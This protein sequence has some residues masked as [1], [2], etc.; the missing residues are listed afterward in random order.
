M[1]RR[2]QRTL[3]RE[4]CY[5]GVGIHFGKSASLTLQPAQANTGII[6][7]RFD[8]SGKQQDVPALLS[9]VYDTGRST[10]LSEGPVIVATVEHLL[11]ALR[12]SNIDN[13]II[14]CSEEEIPIGDGSSNI[15][16]DLIDEAGICEQKE[17]VS[18]ARLS[19]P[20]Y[21]QAQDIFLAAFPFDKLKISYTLHYPQSPTIGTQYRSLIIT[22]ESFRKEIAP[23][24]TFALYNELCWLMNKGLIGG[25]CLE[26]AVVFKDDGIISRGQ[27][28]FSDEPVR[29]K[30]LDLIG[31]L[32]LVG[33][34]FV[35]HVLA[36]G[37]GHASN[38]AL[39]KKILEVLYL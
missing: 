21:Y 39:G 16:M 4:V 36:V 18:I 1:L 15:F 23:C 24:R 3:K 28:R 25:G 9:H 32:S 6:F 17:Q 33:Q 2:T 30:I 38:I 31:D 11:A 34:P 22:E 27:L 7:R 20:V 37:S 13:A 19:C 26:N 5:S 12:S 35:A 14:Q 29:H 10:T 8:V